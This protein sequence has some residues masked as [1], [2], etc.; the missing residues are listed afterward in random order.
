MLAGVA[1]RH[2]HIRTNGNGGDEK[3]DYEAGT[4]THIRIGH[5]TLKPNK[6]I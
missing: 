4:R 1:C 2:T 5:T 6:N 3:F